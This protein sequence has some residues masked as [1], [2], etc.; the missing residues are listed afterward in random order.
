MIQRKEI[1]LAKENLKLS[2]GGPSQRQKSDTNQLIKA[3]RH[4]HHLV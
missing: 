1:F 4:E 3:L 2:S